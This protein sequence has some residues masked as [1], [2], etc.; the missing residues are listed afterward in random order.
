MFQQNSDTET[1]ISNADM[2]PAI[3]P[4]IRLEKFFRR[5]APLQIRR[6]R[7]QSEAA[8]RVVVVFGFF[9]PVRVSLR[10]RSLFAHLEI[11]VGEVNLS[12]NF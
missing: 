8:V 2:P 1:P 3:M 5:A 10:F 9:F 11:R 12:S 4:S 7:R 6:P